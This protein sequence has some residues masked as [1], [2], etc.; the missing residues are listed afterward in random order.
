[1][2]AIQRDKLNHSSACPLMYQAILDHPR[3]KEF[4]LSSCE[5][6]STPWRRWGGRCWSACIAE[7]CPNFVLSSGQTEMYPATT[8]SQPD[9]AAGALRQLL[10]RIADRQRNRDHG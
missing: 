6:A 7:L 3:R 1:M 10:G 8:M 5:P 9:R 2:E 4:D